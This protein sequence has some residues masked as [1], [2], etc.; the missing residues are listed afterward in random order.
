MHTMA[1]ATRTRPIR[2]ETSPVPH[3]VH[4]FV[5]QIDVGTRTYEVT[6]PERLPAR[7]AR[8]RL[9]QMLQRN[10]L[11][12]PG[13]R[14]LL[15]GVRMEGPGMEAREFNQRSPNA[16]LDVFRDTY[17]SN[18]SRAGRFVPMPD[19]RVAALEQTKRPKRKT[20]F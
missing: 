4:R 10:E 12:G 5:Y 18:S 15:A 13:G 11:V 14:P 3:R 7:G 17:L 8:Q 20:S 1:Q 6:L 16:R 9:F 19:V 2:E